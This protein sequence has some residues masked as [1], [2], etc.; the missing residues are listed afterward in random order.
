MRIERPANLI[1]FLV[2]GANEALNSPQGYCL[3]AEFFNTIKVCPDIVGD[4]QIRSVLLD[5]LK[6]G[7]WCDRINASEALIVAEDP[8]G[9]LHLTYNSLSVHPI[10]GAK[11]ELISGWNDT[12]LLRH[13]DKLTDECID[14]LFVFPYSA[15]LAGHFSF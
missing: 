14:L 13:A 12:A 5:V 15:K 9:I 11:Q 3:P 4:T 6:S 8:L 10:N 7:V 1:D 2:A